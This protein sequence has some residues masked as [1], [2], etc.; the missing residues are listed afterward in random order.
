MAKKKVEVVSPSV[1]PLA[2]EEDVTFERE[3]AGEELL[4]KELHPY[5]P[6]RKIAAQSM[7]MKYPFTGPTGEYGEYPGMV[8]D[9]FIV[10]WLRTLPDNTDGEDWTP[11]KAMRSP[12]K[13]FDAAEEWATKNNFTSITNPTIRIFVQTMNAIGEAEFSL[14][15]DDSGAPKAIEQEGSGPLV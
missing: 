11:R 1:D 13:A 2:P 4:G 5:S 15:T 12:G 8:V 9:A 10:C 14:D 3:K 6:S 7:G